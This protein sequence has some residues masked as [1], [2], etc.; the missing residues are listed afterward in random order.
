MIRKPF[1]KFTVEVIAI[2]LPSYSHCVHYCVQLCAVLKLFEFVA[3][4]LSSYSNHFPLPLP[5]HENTFFFQQVE[6]DKSEAEYGKYVREDVSIPTIPSSLGMQVP[7]I[8]QATVPTP[9]PP[10]TPTSATTPT[11][12]SV[13]NGNGAAKTVV[14]GDGNGAA[15]KVPG[16]GNGNG[17]RM[18]DG[19]N[20]ARVTDEGDISGDKT[21]QDSWTHE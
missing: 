7:R 13:T 2:V 6:R 10:T 4:L 9:T 5:C 19:G 17:A 11:K 12:G 18:P 8:Y 20:G 16:N 15:T 3:Y 14:T 21:P 1:R